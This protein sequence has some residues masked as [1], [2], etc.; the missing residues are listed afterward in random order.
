MPE[1]RKTQHSVMIETT[2][3][4]A[5]EALTKASEL[6]EW[7][8]DQAW[9]E[10]RP[11]GRYALHWI[12][13]YH[14]E[15]HFIELEPPHKATVTWQGTGEPGKTQVDYAVK[16]HDGLVEVSVMHSG[17]GPEEG[18]DEALAE[19]EKGWAVGLENLKSTLETGIDLR[20]ARQPFLGITL[21]L[22]TPERAE[23]E[24]IAAEWGIYVTGTVEGSGAEEAGLCTGDVIVALGGKDVPGFQELGTALREHQAGDVVDLEV[25]HGQDRETMRI[26]LSQRPQPELPDSAGALADRLAERQAEVNDELR[27]AVTGLSDKEAEQSP[28][29]DEWSV[30]QVLAH[31]SDGE[32]A[33]HM[34]V[35]NM[36]LN[37]W[38]DA[39]PVYPDQIPGRLAAILAVTPTLPAL[40][41]R[42]LADER[43]TVELVRRLPQET[44]AHKARFRRIAQW[45]I[46]GPDHTREHVQQIKDIVEH[47]RER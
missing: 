21:D 15:G 8:S 20:T 19:A 23:R 17:F 16:S 2:N 31:L 30:K 3:E 47:L 44:L 25:V 6:R 13:G 11:G 24:G 9:T 40:V 27:A 22:L 36:A 34:V 35:V 42:F 28:S 37:G 29:E 1:K 5:F 45:T 14:V 12:Q 39:G 46:A 43:E 26:R 10:V 7:F 38:L 18:W 32:R 4:L 41:D 33:F